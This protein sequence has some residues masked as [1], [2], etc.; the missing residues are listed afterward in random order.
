MSGKLRFLLRGHTMASPWNS[1]LANAVMIFCSSVQSH[2][3]HW[4]CISRSSTIFTHRCGDQKV[5]LPHEVNFSA[6]D[7]WGRKNGLINCGFT[8][9]SQFLLGLGLT[10]HLR[11][12]EE[13]E[14]N[15]YKIKEKLVFLH[16][17][18]MSMGKKIKVLIQQKGLQYPVLS[19][20][21]FSQPLA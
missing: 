9:Q 14:K 11:K 3:L 7:L 12:I 20:L 21:K 16:T 19:G 15:S 17:L 10:D 1:P 4:P 13:A 2:S 18:L 6:L 5:S 8:N